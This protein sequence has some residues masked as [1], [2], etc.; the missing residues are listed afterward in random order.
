[1]SSTVVSLHDSS[2]LRGR[3]MALLLLA[4]VFNFVDRSIVSI[5]KIP[6]KAEFGLSD[7]QLGLLG[8]LAFAL[9]YTGLGVPVAW[10]ADRSNRV[11]IVSA[12]MALWSLMT[13]LCGAA[14]GFWTL[15]LARMGVG[16]GE[17]GGVAP[18]YSI[19]TDY[20]PPGARARALAF[21]SFGIPIGTALGLFAGGWL[22]QVYGWRTAFV[23]IGLAGVLIAPLVLRFVPEPP[24]GRYDVTAVKLEPVAF[25]TA[26]ARVVRIPSFWLLSLGAACSSILGYGLAFW[27]PSLYQ[28]QYGLPLTQVGGFSAIITLVGGITGIWLGGWLSDRLGPT[29]PGAYALVPAIA[30]FLTPPFYLLAFSQIDLMVAGAIL[31]V[32]T[33]LS[34]AWLGPVNAAVQHIVQPNMR[35]VTA[36]LL[37]FVNNLI[38]LGVGPLLLGA[39][40]D[41]FKQSMPA[42]AALRA[43]LEWSLLIYVVAGVFLLLAASRLA[44]D[45]WR[46]PAATGG[47][48]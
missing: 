8:G 16:V 31:I 13:A 39:L 40:S 42:E 34:L 21:F 12:A 24:R 48:V 14:T 7:T 32:P 11:R 3:V 35:A 25:G 5:L 22:A 44:R 30:F 18:S 10:L 33:A 2:A 4:Y 19:V 36:A 1:M 28:Q 37:L 26:V 15:F 43:S 41:R 20:Y 29:R 45:W 9:L 17:A 23:V 47:G 6:I 46:E 38:G 27:L